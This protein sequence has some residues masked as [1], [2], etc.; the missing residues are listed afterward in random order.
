[1]GAAEKAAAKRA[2]EGGMRIAA[3]DAAKAGMV[4]LFDAA[5][6][7]QVLGEVIAFADAAFS[8]ADGLMPFD[9]V[10][11]FG[12]ECAATV[13]ALVGGG[14]VAVGE[15]PA[16]LAIGVGHRLFPFESAA[17]IVAR[18]GAAGQ[19]TRFTS[20]ALLR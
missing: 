1:M 15:S 20:G 11:V 12:A 6:V 4:A 18:E 7:N 13:L 10:G 17:S 14:V 16:E 2:F 19:R 9:E 3:F 5:A 8:R